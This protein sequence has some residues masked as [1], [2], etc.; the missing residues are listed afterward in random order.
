MAALHRLSYNAGPWSRPPAVRHSTLR[1][2]LRL[3]AR[4]DRAGGAILR[5]LQWS[6]SPV[7]LEAPVVGGPVS[8]EWMAQL[9]W[10]LKALR[11][12]P[13]STSS[14]L[15]GAAAIPPRGAAD[16]VIPRL[17]AAKAATATGLANVKITHHR[18]SRQVPQ[19]NPPPPPPSLFPTTGCNS[20]TNK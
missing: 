18:G 10:A 5:L 4:S 13:I 16:P 19:L 15:N 1:S 17:A 3:D 12:E 6:C 9:E 7:F 14:M 2:S 11:I 20:A 8:R